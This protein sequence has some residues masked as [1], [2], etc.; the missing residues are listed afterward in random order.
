MGQP[1]EEE[2]SCLLMKVYN[3]MAQFKLDSVNVSSMEFIK[4]RENYFRGKKIYK[5]NLL[6]I[7]CNY[8]YIASHGLKHI[9]V[10]LGVMGKETIDFEVIDFIANHVRSCCGKIKQHRRDYAELTN[11]TDL[12]NEEV[13]EKL[14]EMKGMLVD[15]FFDN[16]KDISTEKYGLLNESISSSA[17][18]E[19]AYDIREMCVDIDA[20]F[21]IYKN[22]SIGGLTDRNVIKES[23]IENQEDQ[24][25]V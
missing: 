5:L 8:I 14:L 17:L 21:E 25:E 1:A 23:E 4:Q 10:F 11:N 16:S 7:L 9:E 19:I 13:I 15:M 20:I 6:K 3:D 2:I 22:F 24:E 12:L 18:Q